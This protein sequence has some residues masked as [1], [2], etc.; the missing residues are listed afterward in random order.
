MAATKTTPAPAPE[1]EDKFKL[2]IEG[3]EYELNTDD[4][5]IGEIEVIEDELDMA[6]ED[7]DWEAGRMKPVRLLAYLLIH[8]DRPDF[9]ME[10]AKRL[11]V[12][13]FDVEE[14]AGASGNGN[15][16]GSAKAKRPTKAAASRA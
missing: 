3:R 1:T 13:S 6:W 10:D 5:E 16:N 9:T 11:K 15:G 7:V 4:L 8:R 14:A 12:S 2:T